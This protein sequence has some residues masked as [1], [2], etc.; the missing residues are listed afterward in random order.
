MR[1]HGDETLCV[2]VCMCVC[3]Y[4]THKNQMYVWSVWVSSG[5]V[6]VCEGVHTHAGSSDCLPMTIVWHTYI[7]WLQKEMEERRKSWESERERWQECARCVCVCV[8]GCVL[9]ITLYIHCG[10]TY[11]HTFI[12]TLTHT[13]ARRRVCVC[14]C[15]RMSKEHNSTIY[16][17]R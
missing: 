4:Y 8:Y 17:I 14:A 7:S 13:H 5:C 6:C 11:I 2:R 9:Y 12:H 3:M 10:C 1:H 15:A 16:H